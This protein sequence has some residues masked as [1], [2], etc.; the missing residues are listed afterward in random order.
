MM[1]VPTTPTQW[2]D[3]EH[4]PAHH[5]TC[6]TTPDAIP[7]PTA[8]LFTDNTPTALLTPTDNTPPALPPTD[9]RRGSLSSTSDASI[10]TSSRRG[11][12]SDPGGEAAWEGEGAWG[13]E[14]EKPKVW[15]PWFM[16]R[17]GSEM[18]LAQSVDR[19]LAGD[20]GGE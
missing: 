3:S 16:G 14:D 12:L 20:G 15:W 4:T 17:M 9:S 19:L 10:P 2:V 5:S 11:S 8:A 18:E 13:G 6:A 7:P 1:E